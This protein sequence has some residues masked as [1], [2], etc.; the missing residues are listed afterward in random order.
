[1]S[2]IDQEPLTQKEQYWYEHIQHMENA[3]QSVSEYARM[4]D[5]SVKCFYNYRS[6]LRK[7]GLL[8][9]SKA[10]PFVKVTSQAQ[11]DQTTIVLANGIRIHT[12][13]DILS[14]SKLIKGVL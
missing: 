8:A 14:L 5:L 2:E 1:M 11:H 13:C 9:P 6:K 10:K 7:K 12:Q 4:H 3:K